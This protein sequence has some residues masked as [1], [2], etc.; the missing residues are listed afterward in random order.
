M[1]RFYGAY[2]SHFYCR[3]VFGVGE[4]VVCWGVIIKLID[5]DVFSIHMGLLKTIG[6]VT[7]IVSISFVIFTFNFTGI[8]LSPPCYSPP[9]PGPLYQVSYFP[10][11]PLGSLFPF[12]LL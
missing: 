4:I 12:F 3:A 6:N 7:I 2:I 11:H 10:R 8:I 1:G 5:A 9:P